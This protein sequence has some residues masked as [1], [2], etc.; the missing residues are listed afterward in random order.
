[1]QHLE[2]LGEDVPCIVVEVS[3]VTVERISGSTVGGSDEAEVWISD[4]P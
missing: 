1:V 3:I 4:A 2:V